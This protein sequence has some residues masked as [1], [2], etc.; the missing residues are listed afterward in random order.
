MATHFPIK[1]KIFQNS[2]FQIYPGEDEVSS[3]KMQRRVWC[4][5]TKSKVTDYRSN[6]SKVASFSE[7]CKWNR[8]SL[9]SLP[10]LLPFWSRRSSRPAKPAKPAVFGIGE[11]IKH[12][13]RIFQVYR[14]QNWYQQ[15]KIKELVLLFYLGTNQTHPYRLQVYFGCCYFTGVNSFLSTDY[16]VFVPFKGL[17]RWIRYPRV[18]LKGKP[19]KTS[20]FLLAFL[21]LVTRRVRLTN[22]INWL[23]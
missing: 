1:H 10:N 6:A 13:F 4:L 12:K 15:D 19:K 9:Q 11:S 20:L 16:S 5:A 14:F 22:T 3:W 17:V 18:S 8:E 2:R 7:F 21:A 23:F